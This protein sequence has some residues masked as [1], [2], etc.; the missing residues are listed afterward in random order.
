MNRKDKEKKNTGIRGLYALLCLAVSAVL[1]S[2]ITFAWYY[3]EHSL[4][5]VSLVQVPVKITISGANR[6]EMNRI[7][8]N[9]TE[10]D[11]INEGRVT[12]RRV[13][14][15]ESTSD[16]YLEIAHTTNIPKMDIKMYSARE[17]NGSGEGN[18]DV[19]GSSG[20][21]NNYYYYYNTGSEQISGDYINKDSSYTGSGKLALQENE[22]GSLHGRVYSSTDSGRVQINAEPLYWKTTDLIDFDNGTYSKAGESTD[23][24]GET[25]AIYYRYFVLE[26]TWDNSASETDM[27]YLMAGHDSN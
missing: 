16:Y 9:L 20:D 12:I 1:L 23:L 6:S 10:D 18:V 17:G 13:F 21:G 3:R 8:L 5:S 15:I 26:L 22:S 27:V 11:M 14:C 2:G 7:S 4:R 24:S 25:V 19:K